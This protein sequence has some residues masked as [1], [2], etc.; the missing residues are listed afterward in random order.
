[1]HLERDLKKEQFSKE[2]LEKE[3]DKKKF[4]DKIE[5]GDLKIQIKQLQINL[6]N[7]T[8]EFEKLK[9]KVFDLQDEKKKLLSQN[10]DL[11][12]EIEKS[13]NRKNLSSQ[14]DMINQ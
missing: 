7:K 1:M 13:R 10:K 5:N 9:T 11:K 2:L 12:V 8:Q 14:M 6:A 3:I 4:K